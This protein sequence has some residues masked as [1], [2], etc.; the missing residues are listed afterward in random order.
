MKQLRSSL[1]ILGFINFTI[2]L[3]ADPVK[4]SPHGKKTFEIYE[5]IISI[6]TVKGHGKVPEMAKYLTSELKSAG[7]ADQDI[8]IIPSGKTVSLVV[9]YRG[10][11]SSGNKPILFLGHMDVVE[12]YAKDWERPPFKRNR[13][14]VDVII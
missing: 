11:D 12:A 8:N 5:K 9:R 7:F 13:S 6:P 4:D 2:T 14:F 3:I 10:D 1:L